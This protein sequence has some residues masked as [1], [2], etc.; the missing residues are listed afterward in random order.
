MKTLLAIYQPLS[1]LMK[2]MLQKGESQ[3]RMENLTF[4]E[5][6]ILMIIYNQHGDFC[7]REDLAS[8]LE[9]DRSNV[10]RAVQKMARKGIVEFAGDEEDRRL[11]H[12]I[13][14]KKGK[15]LKK[16]IF[17]VDHLLTASLK[18]TLS[19][20]EINSLSKLLQ[21]AAAGMVKEP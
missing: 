19:N 5:I 1:S 16:D 20:E 15:E 13:L 8:E 6:R 12:L 17:S 7:T 11:S 21:K 18:K 10:S 3:V 14:T 9:I 4:I 2:H